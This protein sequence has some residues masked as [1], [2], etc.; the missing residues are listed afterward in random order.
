MGGGDDKS[1][2]CKN[3]LG[4]TLESLQRRV[5]MSD[6]KNF[7]NNCSLR[8]HLFAS[9]KYLVLW[10]F[11]TKILAIRNWWEYFSSLILTWFH[12]LLGCASNIHLHVSHVNTSYR[13]F[14]L[15]QSLNIFVPVSGN[16]Q[17]NTSAFGGNGKSGWNQQEQC[18]VW[19]PL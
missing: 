6:I 11:K 13:G 19:I 9:C 1:P 8:Q 12:A 18:I 5:P 15:V 2:P 4:K 16:P 14:L 10:G 3:G 7:T 17:Q